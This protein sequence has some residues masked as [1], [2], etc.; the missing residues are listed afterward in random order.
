MK[1]KATHKCASVQKVVGQA[2][3]GYLESKIKE[4]ETRM[5]AAAAA[6]TATGDGDGRGYKGWQGSSSS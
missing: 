2:G 3:G 1:S 6:A 4:K 5:A